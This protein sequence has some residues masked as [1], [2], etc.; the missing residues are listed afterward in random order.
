MK[1]YLVRYLDNEYGVIDSIVQGNYIIRTYMGVILGRGVVDKLRIKKVVDIVDYVHLII[2]K[3]GCT[4]L[5]YSLGNDRGRFSIRGITG[6]LNLMKKDCRQLL[7]V[8][9]KLDKGY[10]EV[11]VVYKHNSFTANEMCGEINAK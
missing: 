3:H 8:N 7:I 9:N 1:C 2:D 6:V 5:A 11:L 10:K 4:Q